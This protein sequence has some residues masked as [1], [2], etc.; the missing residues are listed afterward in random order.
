MSSN[1]PATP[2]M[3]HAELA[4]TDEAVHRAIDS[5][6]IESENTAL[7]QRL[8]ALMA[9]LRIAHAAVAVRDSILR[10]QTAA[11]RERE[12]DVAVARSHVAAIQATL[13]WRLTRKA[14][15]LLRAP[16]RLVRR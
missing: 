14:A 6:A 11:L 7:R 8:D 4:E 16:R 1:S 9:E 13:T 10:E 2:E 3:W 5:H 12:R 15:T